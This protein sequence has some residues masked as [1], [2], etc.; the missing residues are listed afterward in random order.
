MKEQQIAKIYAQAFRQLSKEKNVKITDEL[1]S[2]VQLLNDVT[3]LENILFLPTFSNEE[4]SGVLEDV[5]SKI[6][7]SELC[8]TLLRM[9][10]KERRMGVLP[11]IYKEMIVQE[12]DEKGFLKG[13]A[14]G[15]DSEANQELIENLKTIV[16]KK[17]GKKIELNYQQ[18]SNI[19]AGMRVTVGDYQIDGTLDSQLEKQLRM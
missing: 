12:D 15:A 2:F 5:L 8:Q 1:A 17:T 11:M 4:K 3:D 10:Q 9:L 7:L 16:A 14:Q 18:A 13:I 6:G 19:S